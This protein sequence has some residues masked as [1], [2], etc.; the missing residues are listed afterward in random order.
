MDRSHLDW[1]FF[2]ASH[3]ALATSADGW[4]EEQARRRPRGRDV[5]ALCR[6][7]VGAL[8]AAGHLRHC[9]TAPFGGSVETLDA[10]AICVLRETLAYHDGLADFAFAMQGLGSGPIVLGGSAEQKAAW[11]PKVARGEAIAAFALSEPDA[12]SDV[13]ALTTQARRDGDGWLIDGC[14]TWISNGGIADFYCIF[15]RTS[16]ATGSRGISAFVVPA[17]TPGLVVAERI[18]VISPHPLARIELSGCRVGA[19]ALLDAEGEGFKLAM[20]TLDIFRASVGAAA[21]GFARRA[22]DAAVAHA[23]SRRM[24]GAT[25]ADREVAQAKLGEMATMIDAAALLVYRAAWQRDAGGSRTT[26]EA[27]MAK[28]AATEWAQQVID[29]SLQMHGALGV[30]TGSIVERLYRDIRALR[31]YEGATE[32]QQLII[33]REALAAGKRA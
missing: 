18:D 17:Q 15:A 21:L 22:L 11:L 2:E 16:A 27:S 31:I 3:R 8:A 25:L 24:F 32:V 19:A 33:G 4:A 1:P 10:R 20:R 28:M 7:W 12:G 9:V 5:D 14:K 29:G 30:T 26:R 23:R 13:G 6:E